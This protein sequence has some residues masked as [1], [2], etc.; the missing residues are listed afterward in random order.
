MSGLIDTEYL[1]LYHGS[2]LALNKLKELGIE[3]E[4]VSPVSAYGGIAGRYEV[5]NKKGLIMPDFHK[6]PDAKRIIEEIIRMYIK[7][8]K[9]IPLSLANYYKNIDELIKNGR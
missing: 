2:T 8:D 7:Q 5:T 3:T 1:L 4:I 6:N 9:N